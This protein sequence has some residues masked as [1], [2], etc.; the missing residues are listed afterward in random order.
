MS[1]GP[2]HRCKITLKDKQKP[3]PKEWLMIGKLHYY[4]FTKCVHQ[5]EIGQ[6]EANSKKHLRTLHFDSARPSTCIHENLRQN[7]T[8]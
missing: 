8:H 6:S 3:R 5:R 4:V 7:K 1:N 2:E